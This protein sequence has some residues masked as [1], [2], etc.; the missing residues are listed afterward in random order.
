MR[1]YFEFST[2]LLITVV[3]LT[4]NFLSLITT[5][6]TKRCQE[7]NSFGREKCFDWVNQQKKYS[8]SLADPKFP[9]YNIQNYP[10][11]AHLNPIFEGNKYNDLVIVTACSQQYFPRLRNLIGSIHFWEPKLSIIVYDIGLTSELVDEVMTWKN[12]ELKEFDFGNYPP[13]VSFIWNF[14]WKIFIIAQEMEN[15]PTVFWLDSGVELRHPLVSVR[16]FLE[17]DG[18]FSTTME[19]RQHITGRSTMQETFDRMKDYGVEELGHY[20]EIIIKNG[21]FCSGFAMGFD[22]REA[23]KS[24]LKYALKCARDEGCISPKGANSNNHNFDQSAITIAA[25]ASGLSHACEHE[26]IVVDT[27][28]YDEATY[29]ETRCNHF[30]LGARRTIQFRPYIQ[31]IQKNEPVAKKNLKQTGS[32]FKPKIVV[33]RRTRL[34]QKSKR[35]QQFEVCVDGCKKSIKEFNEKFQQCVQ[36]CTYDTQDYW[37]NVIQN[38]QKWAESKGIEWMI[39]LEKGRQCKFVQRKSMMLHLATTMVGLSMIYT[40][41]VIVTQRKFSKLS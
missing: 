31:Y 15:H 29:D 39:Y 30:E 24:I 19:K 4:I 17:R 18:F 12:V 32:S 34:G 5:N 40:M 16:Y 22:Q 20:D 10:K 7:P 36:K 28:N 37:G 38:F 23:S 35:D 27:W 26:N 33:E 25:Y 14:A 2:V 3:S 9:L 21:P 8:P 1:V 41:K 13:Y 6:V 11:K